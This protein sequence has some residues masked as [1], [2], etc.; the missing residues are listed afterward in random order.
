MEQEELKK[1]RVRDGL[2][3]LDEETPSA[4][5]KRLK[6]DLL[7]NLED[8]PNFVSWNPDLDSFMMSFQKE[9]NGGSPPPEVVDLTSHSGES[10]PELGY[11]LEA[12]DDELGL[13]PSTASPSSVENDV[14][15]ELIRVESD[16]SE[17]G[18]GFWGFD[19]EIPSY[20]SFEFGV[21][22]SENYGNGEYVAL[23]GLF[24]Y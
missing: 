18:H 5:V 22:E 10:Q 13:P 23:D 20:Y 11:L 14:M 4:E 8:D 12:S 3:E 24:D 19:G 6:E 15:N 17:L 7:E 2:V 1:K 21:F 16:L 9:I